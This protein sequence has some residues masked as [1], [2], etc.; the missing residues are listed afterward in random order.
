MYHEGRPKRVR[1]DSASTT[2]LRKARQAVAKVLEE[3]I[4]ATTTSP[5][6][7]AAGAAGRSLDP[8]FVNQY[9]RN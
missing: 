5:G 4:D 6:A 3:W 8:V 7:G 2:R 9:H 1:T